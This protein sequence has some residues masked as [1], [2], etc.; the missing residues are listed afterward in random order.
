M[1]NTTLTTGP[2][3]LDLI[4]YKGDTLNLTVYLKNAD[5]S[6]FDLSTGITN[7]SASGLISMT[8]GASAVSASFAQVTPAGG[9][10]AAGTLKFFLSS[11]ESDK[12]SSSY[13]NGKYDIQV[14]YTK[15]SQ[16]I[17]RTILYGG[18]TVVNDVTA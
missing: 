1:A 10:L 2:A 7:F 18:V 3:L 5:A 17:V 11:T 15:S 8:N 14:K 9:E 12:V 13:T 6:A 4:V 16:A